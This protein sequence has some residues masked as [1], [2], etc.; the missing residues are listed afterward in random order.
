MEMGI[1]PK[2]IS[3]SLVCYDH[4]SAYFFTGNLPIEIADHGEYH[5]RNFREKLSV[6]AEEH[7]QGFQEGE[8]K[9]S[10]RKTQQ[11]FLIQVF[12]KE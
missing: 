6:V 4:S 12:G 3:K 2:H 1:T 10:M 11:D 9:L 5:F 7:P 8:Y